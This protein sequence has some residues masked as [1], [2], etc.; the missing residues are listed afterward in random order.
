MHRWGAKVMAQITH[1]GRR[2]NGTVTEQALVA[3]SP[4]YER[5]S[6]TVPRAL[7]ADEIREIVAAYAAAARRL[8]RAGFDGAEISGYARHLIDQFW[9]PQINQRDDEYGGSFVNRMR[10]GVEVIESVREAVGSDF[11]VGLRIS[12]DELIPGGRGIEGAKEIVAYL[13]QLGCLDYFSVAG[14]TGEPVSIGHRVIPAFDAPQGVYAQYAAE[15]RKATDRPVLYTGRVSDPEFADSLIAEGI[16]DLVGMTRALIADPHLPNKVAADALQEVKPCVAMQQGCVGRGPQGLYTGCTHNP[17]IGR[18]KELRD[19]TPARTTRRVLVIGGG[20][21]GLE[22]AR[23]A[24]SRGHQVT[25]LEARPFL[26]GRVAISSRAPMRPEWGQ[27]IDWLVRQAHKAGVEVRTGVEADAAVVA[28]LQPD[29]VVVATGSTPHLP[30]L[31]GTDLPGVTTAEDVFAHPPQLTT[32]A[33]CLVVDLFGNAEAGLAAHALAVAGHRVRI[34][35]PYHMIAEMEE[36]STRAPVYDNLCRAGW[37]SSLT[38]TSWP[39]DLAIRSLWNWSRSTPEAPAVS[40]GSNWSSSA[41]AHARAMASTKSSRRGHGKPI[42]SET[43]SL[44]GASSRRCWRRPGSR[45]GC[46]QSCWVRGLIG[47]RSGGVARGPGLAGR[48]SPPG[49]PRPPHPFRSSKGIRRLSGPGTGADPEAGAVPVLAG[50]CHV[51]QEGALEAGL[52][53]YVADPGLLSQQAQRRRAEGIVLVLR[54]RL[55]ECVTRFVPQ[56]EDTIAFIDDD[57]SRHHERAALAVCTRAPLGVITG[58][59]IHRHQRHLLGRVLMDVV[60]EFLDDVVVPDAHGALSP[61]RSV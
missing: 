59:V 8:Q 1:R 2:G 10:F 36:K 54:L 47:F 11:T 7:R 37:T 41:T 43:R 6:R 4:V 45:A 39:S 51:D 32:P 60:G 12:G 30:Q 23:V 15:V 34:L 49:A 38:R 24:S 53:P 3:P 20:P 42:S 33:S 58:S 52:G 29:A 5:V 40:R 28:E 26:G 14:A 27:S 61:L 56:A 18:E 57:C 22:A 21:G 25:L 13:D 50:P 55:C 16:C 9:S 44:R 31:P 35:T 46:D 48:R 17:V 19:T